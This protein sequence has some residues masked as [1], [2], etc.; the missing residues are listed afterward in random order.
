MHNGVF[1]T[2]EAT[3]E[4]YQKAQK[5]ETDAIHPSLSP[6]LL[7]EEIRDLG[8]AFLEDGAVAAIVAF[9][10]SLE[11]DNFDKSVPESVPSGLNPGGAI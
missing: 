6:H 2:L 9:L 8:E 4:F 7:D 11:D 3:V 10:K 5:G 1:E